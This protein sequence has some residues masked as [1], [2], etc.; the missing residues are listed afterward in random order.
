MSVQPTQPSM[1]QKMWNGFL[2]G[3][4]VMVV[5]TP[6]LNALNRVSAICCRDNIS[7]WRAIDWIHE[8]AIDG[9]RKRSI[10]HFGVGMGA[11]LFR[12]TNRVFFKSMGL[13]FKPTLD[14]HFRNSPYGKQK[15]DW[16]FS[17]SLAVA[18]IAINPAD[19][20]RIMWQANE[21]LSMV[22]KG[23]RISH[24]YKGAGANGVKQ[25][26]VW[27]LY[28]KSERY[29]SRVVVDLTGL[30]PGSPAGIALKSLPMSL[31]I[32]VPVW[33]FERLKNV[34][35]M[36]PSLMHHT[37]TKYRYVAAW[38]QV[39]G[40]QGAKGLLRGLAAKTLYTAFQAMGANYMLEE[41]RKA[42]KK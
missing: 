10:A 8:G 30:D 27:L 14:E 24:L 11:H 22:R 3:T 12:E 32:G 4:Q 18:E 17:G 26:G 25:L 20:L 31:H 13:L 1:S 6:L 38:R 37:N 40:T 15:A 21:N 42:Q 2:L 5:Q 35:Q 36:N 7:M 19:T 16:A 41:A 34:L 9:M 39:L 28:S 29:W 33:V 23:E